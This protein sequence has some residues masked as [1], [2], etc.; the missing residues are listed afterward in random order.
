MPFSGER[1]HTLCSV[2]RVANTCHSLHVVCGH[3]PVWPLWR[4]EPSCDWLRLEKLL[5]EKLRVADSHS[6]S[7]TK[8]Q[9]VLP[10]SVPQ[11]RGLVR[12]NSELSAWLA[13]GQTTARLF[14]ESARVKKCK[15]QV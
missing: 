6:V 4:P 3:R 2:A 7:K 11:G 15:G 8:T 5:R 12:E 14:Q 9:G 1:L 10:A 13:A